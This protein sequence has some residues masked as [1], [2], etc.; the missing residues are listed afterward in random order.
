M[1][2]HICTKENDINEIK[3]MVGEIHQ[4][5]FVGNGTP[6]ICTRLDRVER[7]V[8]AVSVAIGTIMLAGLVGG[9]TVIFQHIWATKP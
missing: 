2:D 7:I 3:T 8:A 1:P 5:L 4:K 9:A 6:A